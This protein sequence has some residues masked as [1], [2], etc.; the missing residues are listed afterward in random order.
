MGGS[1]ARRQ[2]IALGRFIVVLS[3]KTSGAQELKS[4]VDFDVLSDQGFQRSV[5]RAFRSLKVIVSVKRDIGTLRIFGGTLAVVRP[6]PTD[7]R[8]PSD[9]PTTIQPTDDGTQRYLA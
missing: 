7:T 9:W 2:A 5:W 4:H 3:V 1:D 8:P 6:I